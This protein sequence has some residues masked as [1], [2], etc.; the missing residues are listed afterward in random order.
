MT[1]DFLVMIRVLVTSV[2]L[3]SLPIVTIAH[4]SVAAN[5]DESVLTELAGDIV[6]VFW[7]NPHVGFTIRV[8]GANGLEENYK[9]PF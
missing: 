7:R 6:R 4:H 3:L 2:M 1:D 8:T 9:S 5:F